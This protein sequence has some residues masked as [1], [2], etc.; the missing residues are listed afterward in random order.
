[1]SSTNFTEEQKKQCKKAMENS[2]DTLALI[3][4]AVNSLLSNSELDECL[5]LAIKNKA[6]E[7]KI[8][9]SECALNL[10]L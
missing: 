6:M 5:L 4:F 10:S 8:N 9:L 7:S 3:E 1:M 2:R